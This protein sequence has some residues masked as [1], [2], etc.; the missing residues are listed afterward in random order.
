MDRAGGAGTRRPERDSDRRDL[1]RRGGHRARHAHHDLVLRCGT[2]RPPSASASACTSAQSSCAVAGARRR[3]APRTRPARGLKR[4]VSTAKPGDISAVDRTS[5][6]PRRG[7]GERDQRG[8]QQ[9]AQAP[10]AKPRTRLSGT[11][12]A[13]T[14]PRKLKLLRQQADAFVHAVGAGARLRPRPARSSAATFR[15]VMTASRASRLSLEMLACE[16][17]G[18]GRAPLQPGI[19]HL[20]HHGDRLQVDDH[21]VLERGRQPPQHAVAR[22]FGAACGRRRP[23]AAEPAATPCAMPVTTLMNGTFPGETAA[24]SVLLRLIA[25]SIVLAAGQLML[26]RGHCGGCRKALSSRL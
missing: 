22:G 1:Q 20:G 6:G 2:A 4:T 3:Q 12:L 18:R 19:Q 26:V 16:F 10:R 8:R 11:S 15:Q 23:L 7:V 21:V 25:P 17:G 24:K 9:V 14:K 13:T 5:P